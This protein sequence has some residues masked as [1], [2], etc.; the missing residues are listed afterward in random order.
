[1]DPPG[2]AGASDLT[3]DEWA[4]AHA[5]LS[6]ARAIYLPSNAG[7]SF[8]RPPLGSPA[9]YLRTGLSQCGEC[10]NG[11]IVKSRSHGQRCAFFSGCGGYHNRGRTVC[12][13]CTET[14]L[15]DGNGIVVEALLGEVLDLFMLE[16]SADEAVRLL[17]GVK[18]PKIGRLRSSAS[19]RRWSRTARGSRRRLLREGSWT[20]SCGRS[21]R[22]SRDS[23]S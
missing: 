8:G 3:E 18:A 5:R 21:R 12:S 6:A 14:F 7:Q 13:N 1:V 2:G 16:D 10:S 11:L 4:A 19:W 20:G 22:A 17:Q 23:G 15:E 9:K